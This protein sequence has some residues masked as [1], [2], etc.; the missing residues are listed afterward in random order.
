MTVQFSDAVRDAMLDATESV[1]GTS[2]ILKI[3]SGAQPADCAAA[4]SGT[5]LAQMNLPSDWMAAA[6]GGAK[7]KSGT[8]EDLLAN[9]T[10]TAGHWRIYDSGLVA[11]HHQGSVG[12]GTGDLQVNTTSFVSGQPVTITSWVYTAGNP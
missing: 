4:D 10:G 6:S 5:L 3:F 1:V 9:N 12:V 8:W 7:A 11:C 2:A